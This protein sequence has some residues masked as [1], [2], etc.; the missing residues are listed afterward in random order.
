[1]IQI[2]EDD[3]FMSQRGARVLR[4]IKF[5]TCNPGVAAFIQR[6]DHPQSSNSHALQGKMSLPSLHRSFHPSMGV[7]LLS[8]RPP[9]QLNGGE[10]CPIKLAPPR[11]YRPKLPPSHDF[12]SRHQVDD[13]VFYTN[14]H[15]AA[16]PHKYRAQSPGLSRCRWSIFRSGMK[17]FLK[18]NSA[19][20]EIGLVQG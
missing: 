12:I 16:R 7:M 17:I 6:L 14:A 15:N 3:Y 13:G 18:W 1:M 8:I 19:T 11:R 10:T 5:C 20:V 4:L 9:E 2:G